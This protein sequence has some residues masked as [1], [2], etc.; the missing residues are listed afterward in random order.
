MTVDS[1]ADAPAV[2]AALASRVLDAVARR[3]SLVLGLPTGRTPKL[4]YAEL[5]RRS[6]G[7]AADWS[8][9]RTFNLD[10]FVGLISGEEGSYRDYM[11]RELFSAVGIPPAHAG[12][13]NGGAPDLDAE[14]DRYERAIAEAGGM[15]LLILGIGANGHVGFNE[16]ADALHARTHRASLAA[17]TRASNAYLFG[18]DAQ[19]V[20]A[21]ALSMGMATILRARAIVLLAT[22]PE[23]RAAVTAMVRGPIR[24][25]LPASFLQLHPDVTVMVDRAASPE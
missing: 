11:E 15:D 16:P 24:T 1:H 7:G 2:A 23:K 14:C 18:G 22:G 10:E 9:V 5:R 20:P 17:A 4:L 13:L 8:A 3:P 25:S 21:E 12:F 6:A 19:R